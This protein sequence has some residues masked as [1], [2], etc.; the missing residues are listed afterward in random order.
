MHKH[1]SVSRSANSP[2]RL[3]SGVAAANAAHHTTATEDVKLGHPGC[4]NHVCTFL[5]LQTS[6]DQTGVSRSLR[7]WCLKCHSK[8][9]AIMNG[10]ATCWIEALC[11]RRCQ[12]LRCCRRWE[13]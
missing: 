3:R 4:H 12:L 9:R 8:T 7:I 11:Q 2:T 1:H 5:F 6:A 10:S 13:R